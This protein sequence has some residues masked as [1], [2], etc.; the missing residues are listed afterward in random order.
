MELLKV[1]VWIDWKAKVWILTFWHNK[2]ALW[3]V[4]NLKSEITCDA[5]RYF[6]GISKKVLFRVSVRWSVHLSKATFCMSGRLSSYFCQL[7]V[8]SE[9]NNSSQ[10]ILL[11]QSCSMIHFGLIKAGAISPNGSKIEIIRDRIPCWQLRLIYCIFY[12][13]CILPWV[14]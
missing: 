7:F 8:R 2:A 14:P 3:L 6:W 13:K 5:I 1:K 9:G 10:S 12:M 4:V 11:F